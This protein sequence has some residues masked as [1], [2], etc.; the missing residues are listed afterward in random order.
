LLRGDSNGQ[1][2][3]FD[4]VVVLDDSLASRRPGMRT[5]SLSA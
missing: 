5:T 4:A 1:V 2:P 3:S